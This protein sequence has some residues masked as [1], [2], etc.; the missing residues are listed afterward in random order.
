MGQSFGKELVFSR[1]PAR[2]G[3]ELAGRQD[4]AADGPALCQRCLP[5]G[6][7]TAGIRLGPPAR[8]PFT[9][10]FLREGSPTKIDYR[11]KGTFILSSLLEDLVELELV[12]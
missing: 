3:S 11:K 1:E 9:V 8:C 6:G 5:E 4:F 2:R 12:F 10:S 7:R